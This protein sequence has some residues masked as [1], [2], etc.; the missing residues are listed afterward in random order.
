MVLYCLLRVNLS[1]VGVGTAAEL[2][3]ATPRP[4]APAAA[5]APRSASRRVRNID[6]GVISDDRMP[7]L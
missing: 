5:R 1:G 3:Q 7:A 4:T 6:S 2:G